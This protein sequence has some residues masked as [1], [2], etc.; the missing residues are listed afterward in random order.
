MAVSST[1]WSVVICLTVVFV[2]RANVI[3]QTIN[4][5]SFPSDLQPE[6]GEEKEREKKEQKKN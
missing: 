6:D 2:F 4:F 1:I 5:L 3:S